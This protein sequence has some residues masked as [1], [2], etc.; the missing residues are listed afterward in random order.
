MIP[1]ALVTGFLGSGKTTL[2]KQ[3]ARRYRDR[4][5]VYL[6]N[7][8][9]ARDVDGALL[10]SETENV[11]SIAGGSIFC[12]CLV[13]DFIEHLRNL[14]SRFGAPDAVVVEASGIAD[15]SSAGTMLRETQLD[16]VYRLSHV[17]AVIDPGSFPKLL[18]TLPNIRAQVQAASRALVNK[19]DLHPPAVIE[20]TEAAIRTLNPNITITR[21]THCAVD[22]D[23]FAVHC[24][25]APQGQPAPCADPR[26]VSFNVPVPHEV[27]LARLREAVNAA[28]TGLYRIK[29]F[30][31]SGGRCLHVDYSASGWRVEEVATAESPALVFV[32]SGPC[33]D[34]ARRLM[35]AV[36][37]GRFMVQTQVTG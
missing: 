16:G 4:R 12:R 32:V 21:T 10:G 34:A 6:V 8:F 1:L 7:E 28:G 35:H 2:L 20:Q 9:S 17:V 25:V 18:H 30:V 29:G 3:L 14:P 22:M 19:T 27:D 26:F 37:A 31:R 15:P 13:T 24:T 11:V 23:I 36:R 5:I 33:S